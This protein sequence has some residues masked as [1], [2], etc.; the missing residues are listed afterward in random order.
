MLLRRFWWW[1]P[2][3]LV[4]PRRTMVKPH[5]TFHSCMFSTACLTS[6]GVHTITPKFAVSTIPIKSRHC[7]ALRLTH[8]ILPDPIWVVLGSAGKDCWKIQS[9][10]HGR[11]GQGGIVSYL[12]AKRYIVVTPSAISNCLEICHQRW[13]FA[14]IRSSNHWSINCP[15]LRPVG[16]PSNWL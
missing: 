10:V 1:G 12:L 4:C 13:K 2:F 16:K 9:R 11:P 5:W 3:S 8:N 14:R 15:R 7:I 6:M